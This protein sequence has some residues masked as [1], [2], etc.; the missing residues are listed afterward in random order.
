MDGLKEEIEK[1]S[2]EAKDGG[3]ISTLD[4]AVSTATSGGSISG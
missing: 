2:K 3:A 4:N 1:K